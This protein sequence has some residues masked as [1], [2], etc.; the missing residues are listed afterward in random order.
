MYSTCLSLS[1]ILDK[2]RR[3]TRGGKKK[4]EEEE[5]EEEEDGGSPWTLARKNK[6]KTLNM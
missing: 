5:E 2:R 6:E 3:G 1:V 4:E